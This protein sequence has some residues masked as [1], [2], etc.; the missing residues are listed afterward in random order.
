MH[1]NNKIITLL[2]HNIYTLQEFNFHDTRQIGDY[3]FKERK[4]NACCME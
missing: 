4:I 3:R 1:N 2:H